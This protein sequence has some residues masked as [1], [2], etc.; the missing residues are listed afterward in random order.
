[1][2]KK[3]E[4]YRILYRLVENMTDRRKLYNFFKKFLGV[5]ND[6]SEFI[7]PDVLPNNLG[8]IMDTTQNLIKSKYLPSYVDDV[9]EGYYIEGVFYKTRIGEPGSYVYSEPYEPETG[10]IYVDL[11][12]EDNTT[13]RWSGSSYIILNEG[14]K[15]KIIIL[16]VVS[17]EY[18]SESFNY[19]YDELLSMINDEK[20]NYIFYVDDKK[21][22]VKSDYLLPVYDIKKH[23]T[24]L[25]VCCTLV[26]KSN[27][28]YRSY[29]YTKANNFNSVGYGNTTIVVKE[30]LAD[31]ARDIYLPIG[32]QAVGKAGLKAYIDEYRIDTSIPETPTD[33]KMLSTKAT[34]DYI[35]TKIKTY[36]ANNVVLNSQLNPFIGEQN[37]ANVIENNKDDVNNNTATDASKCHIEGA[38]NK[39]NNVSVSHIEGS[40]NQ[41]NS[42][43]IVHVEGWNNKLSGESAIH[44]EGA[45]VNINS[46]G[47]STRSAYENGAHVGGV[48]PIDRTNEEPFN[49]DNIIR[50][51]GCGAETVSKD[52]FIITKSGKIY[53]KNI[54]TFTGEETQP[55]G[56]KDIATVIDDIESKA[57]SA[58]SDVNG[59]KT[60]ITTI[61]QNISTIESNINTINTS[62]EEH[63]NSISTNTDNISAEITRA[64]KEEGTITTN[65]N[66]EIEERKAADNTLTQNV[67]KEVEDRKAAII[68][69]TN[70]LATETSERKAKDE[71]LVTSINDEITNREN[72]ISTETTAR[73]EG[74]N[75]LTT[76]ITT[77]ETRAKNS[78]N[79]ISTKVTAI[80]EKIP[81]Q[82][83]KDNQLADKEFVNS[84]ISTATAT[85]R[86]TFET[87]V[88][89]NAVTEADNNDYAFYKH[90]DDAGNTLFDKYCY[91]G[92]DWQYQCTLN[93]SSFT[94]A[95]W[96]A[97]NSEVT[98][99]SI[100]EL[101]NKVNNINVEPFII[102]ITSDAN[103]YH[104]DK[105]ANEIHNACKQNKTIILTSDDFYNG[106]IL[107]VTEI[108][109]DNVNFS[110]TAYDTSFGDEMSFEWSI[111]GE[112]SNGHNDMH[113]SLEQN[114]YVLPRDIKPFIITLTKSGNTYTKDKTYGDINDAITNKKNI[115]ILFT[116]NVLYR[117]NDMLS[118]IENESGAINLNFEKIG[119]DIDTTVYQL[120]IVVINASETMSLN[121]RVKNIPTI[122][123]S[124]STNPT[125]NCVPSTKLMK[126]YVDSN[127]GLSS[128]KAGKG[129]AS[130][131]HNYNKDGD[132]FQ[133]IATGEYSHVEGHN[134]KTIGDSSH[135]EGY[136]NIAQGTYSHAEGN[137]TTAFDTA[138]HA[139]GIY[140]IAK[141]SACH[142]EGKYNV[143]YSNSIH[144]VGIGNNL[145]IISRKNA[146]TITIDGKHYIPNIGNYTGVETDLTNI[147]D[148]ATIIN[149]YESRIAAL[150]TALANLQ[151]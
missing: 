68:T 144:E 123:T 35:D 30:Q 100:Q 43:G 92:M 56:F 37:E 20:N 97:I 88:E 12:T 147:K 69:L 26:Y 31:T 79:A 106:S 113:V 146:H 50:Q 109:Y 94:A 60:Q 96:A 143:G 101:T 136:G 23:E 91:D 130:E 137:K 80:E 151:S 25:E 49:S 121:S 51:I 28:I 44:I 145:P 99:T 114:P 125:D 34:I 45:Y 29:D 32:K 93:N 47:T 52:A 108:S 111:Y 74:D 129:V 141:Y 24:Y 132:S 83:S 61:N 131:I 128:I 48:N 6:D 65:L 118:T 10:K 105:T 3:G 21:S 138:S 59:I 70:N 82:A 120:A 135:S 78:E 134:N 67:N 84:S 55:K 9:L 140:T 149:N 150:E 17:N 116:D 58:S 76:K 139:E 64:K 103:G 2:I 133:N 7:N 22:S 71:L 46:T 1:M 66:K 13:Y 42:T 86:G 102:T 27:I 14:C 15:N 104:V 95:Q 112:N 72:A 115:Y 127:K 122:D 4:L 148:L 5:F 98:K 90:K 19:T 57:N 85:F 77:E 107:L 89:L 39:I 8:D 18:S 142:A 16:K 81:N 11:N 38:N 87:L 110:I 53:I 126:S 75:T 73:K 117:V 119:T 124:V 62:I 36:P 54:G 41:V 40:S 63:T 33:T